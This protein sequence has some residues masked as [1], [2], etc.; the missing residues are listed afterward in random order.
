MTPASD[1]GTS[2]GMCDTHVLTF[3]LTCLRCALALTSQCLPAPPVYSST[4]AP[5]SAPESPP[6]SPPVKYIFAKSFIIRMYFAYIFFIQNARSRA[7]AFAD[8]RFDL[9]YEI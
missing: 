4:P 5:S 9:K 7:R 3:N 2:V 8:H 1:L 6:K